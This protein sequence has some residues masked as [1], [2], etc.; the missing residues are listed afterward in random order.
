MTTQTL[1][2]ELLT[3]E[4]PPKAL[5]NLGNHF[6]ASVVEGL[7]KAQLI[8]SDPIELLELTVEKYTAYAS[9]RRLAV[10]VKNVKAVQADQKIVKKGPAV[11]NA[12]KDGAPT[13]ALE[14][15]ARG[16][17]AKIEDLTIIHD[18]KQDVYAYEY[19]QTGKPLGELLE[20]IINAAV[21][22]LPIPK[23]MRWG[24][25][26]SVPALTAIKNPLRDGD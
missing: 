21:K 2:I 4:L 20:D 13:K 15:F 3:E 7:E 17:G 19:D 8:D 1:L 16:A 12:M 5:N 9:P 6:A 25:S 24:S 10:Q 18:G 23:V 26:K 11:A 14:G 22:K